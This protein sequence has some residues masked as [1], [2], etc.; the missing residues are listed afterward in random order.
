MALGE[1]ASR[2]VDDAEEEEE[3]VVVSGS[4][5]TFR[6]C[7]DGRPGE[8]DND[9]VRGGLSRILSLVVPSQEKGCAAVARRPEIPG[10]AN[11]EARAREDRTHNAMAVRVLHGATAWVDVWLFDDDDHD[12]HDDSAWWSPGRFRRILC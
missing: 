1:D 6:T 10:G 7:R 11:A 12:D 5:R 8:I 9:V 2:D 3:P 4:D